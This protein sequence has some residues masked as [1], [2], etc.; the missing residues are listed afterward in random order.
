M[1][2]CMHPEQCSL[3]TYLSS[4]AIV[5]TLFFF[6]HSVFLPNQTVIRPW[7]VCQALCGSVVPELSLCDTCGLE[8]VCLRE[9]SSV[10]SWQ[11]FS[12]VSTVQCLANTAGLG[13]AKN[14]SVSTATDEKSQKHATKLQN[15]F[16]RVDFHFY[17]YTYG[18]EPPGVPDPLSSL[19]LRCVSRRL[20][21]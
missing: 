9:G 10:S 17:W 21:D 12:S 16:W 4:A 7:L 18:G 6:M 15:S 11:W 8:V 1:Q 3:F 13:A 19:I 14:T 2:C 5:T 20:Q